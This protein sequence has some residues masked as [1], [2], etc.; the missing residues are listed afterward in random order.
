MSDIKTFKNLIVL[1]NIIKFGILWEKIAICL[2]I[3]IQ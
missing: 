3:S 2:K 1:A